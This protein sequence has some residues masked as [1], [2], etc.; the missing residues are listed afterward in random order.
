MDVVDRGEYEEWILEPG[1][2]RKMSMGEDI[3]TVV[4]NVLIDQTAEGAGLEI[5]T[6]NVADFTIRNVGWKGKGELEDGASKYHI[7]AW[8]TGEG[9][10]ENVYMN[11]KNPNG[12]GSQM[13]GVYAGSYHSGHFT[14]RKSFITGMGNNACY[15]SSAADGGGAEGTVTVEEAYHRDCGPSIFRIG[16][17]GSAVRD[18]VGVINDPDGDRGGYIYGGS[19]NTRMMWFRH[20]PDLTAENVHLYASAEDVS[21]TVEGIHAEAWNAEQESKSNCAECV[22]NV[23][24]CEWDSPRKENIGLNGS[25]NYENTGQNPQNILSEGV[26]MTPEMAARGESE[27]PDIPELDGSG[28]N[29]GG[30]GSTEYPHTLTVEST[31]G[32]LAEWSVTVDG[33]VR[34]GPDL[35]EGGVH[36]SASGSTAEG[37][38]GPE[39][40]ADD[41]EFNG[42]I[43]DF[44]LTGPANVYVNGTQYDVSEMSGL[45]VSP[46][47][48]VSASVNEREVTVDA[49]DSTY[50][51]GNIESYTF[52]YPMYPEYNTTKNSPTHT[53][54][55]TEGQAGTQASVQ[56]TVEAGGMTDTAQTS[57]TPV[58]STP[59]DAAL[60]VTT[61]GLTVTLDATGSNE[62]DGGIDD[63]VFRVWRPDGESFSSRNSSGTFTFD[64]QQQGDY[65]AAV[66]VSG[67]EG[68]DTAQ[69]SFG[70]SRP[71]VGPTVSITATAN[72]DEVTLSGDSSVDPDGSI[73][74]YQW[75][76]TAPD[77]A[78]AEYQTSN[79]TFEPEQTGVYDAQLT[80]EDDVG[81]T[82][83]ASA[84]FTVS[85]GEN[86]GPI[87]VI[88]ANVQ[89]DSVSLS[90]SESVDPDGSITDYDWIVTD[91]EGQT[92]NYNT[93]SVV[94][95][96]QRNG[97]WNVQLTTTD[98]EGT[99][100]TETAS[101]A[102]T[103]DGPQV[104]DGDTEGDNSLL[105]LS[106]LYGASRLL[107]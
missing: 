102:V 92:T 76:V 22:G 94:F 2:R 75:V 81:A 68:E 97:V 15:L 91:P 73:T 98:N 72:P 103:E 62:G 47:A 33:E 74:A 41:V 5:N 13:G 7:Q 31:G 6:S 82:A 100:G 52:S 80:V 60:G 106:L 70:V 14:L 51:Y 42:K 107:E 19:Y 45:P 88:N 9:L 90:A 46:S 25:I 56:V 79:V 101:F 96:A 95:T 16:S 78:S 40:G 1:E 53:F 11:G 30:G 20:C 71:N 26:P 38:V 58:V 84:Q 57:F 8:C 21:W 55:V 17:P 67:P 77:G 27:I 66:R 104:G 43:T 93:E 36:D 83:T 48:V 34:P 18:S 50:Q 87:P 65:T 69:Q 63:Y 10:I 44:S 54:E 64:A 4:E 29:T 39:G 23:I 32:G 35:E 61:D 3:G 12:D 28:G 37:R 24:N 86:E 105:S 59:P 85:Q 99:A 49:S 89:G